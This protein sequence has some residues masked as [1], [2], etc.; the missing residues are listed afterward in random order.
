MSTGP[1]FPVLKLLLPIRAF[2]VLLF[3]MGTGK[4]LLLTEAEKSSLE[5]VLRQ[6]RVDSPVARRTD[7]LLLSNRGWNASPVADALFLDVETIRDWRR[8]FVTTGLDVLPLS[9]YSPRAGHP[10]FEQQAELKAHPAVH[11]PRSTR[12]VRHHVEK[13]YGT[14]FPHSGMI[15]LMARL[16]FIYKKP[17]ALPL[18]AKESEQREFIRH[19][20]GFL[21]SMDDDEA[22]VPGDAVHPEHQSRPAYGWYLRENRPAIAATSGRKRLDI[23]GCLNPE[24]FRFQFVEAGKINAETTRQLLQKVEDAYPQKRII[25]VFLDNAR[26]HHARIL[27][28]WPK[29]TDRRVKL[30][31]LPACAPHS[32]PIERLWAIMHRSI[33]HDTYYRKPDDFTEAILN[34]FCR[35]L[36]EKWENFRSTVTDNF[37][38]ITNDN[39]RLVG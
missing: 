26:Y 6:R 32:N 15:K 20:N 5:A 25:H 18:A 28:P 27:Q 3:V 13:S 8:G 37:T 2:W 24:T 1:N 38:V 9:P 17:K 23:H 19:C 35:T 7:A 34:F 14:M 4:S 33:T 39:Y 30:H 11:P 21:N 16:G 22:V 36:P 31:F 12:A 29:S 10:D